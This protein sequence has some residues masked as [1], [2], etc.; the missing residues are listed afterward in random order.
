[1]PRPKTEAGDYK[2][3]ML[4][5]PE[6]M[7]RACKARAEQQRRS[8]NAQLLCV[9]DEWLREPEENRS[10]ELVGSRNH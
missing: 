7:L 3:L 8:L 1:M 6:P 2:G 5:L 10:H 9:I 4:R